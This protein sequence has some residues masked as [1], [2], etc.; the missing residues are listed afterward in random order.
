MLLITRLNGVGDVDDSVVTMVFGPG[1][2]FVDNQIGEERLLSYDFFGEINSVELVPVCDEADE[3]TKGI[4]YN[5][6]SIFDFHR[7]NSIKS[8][9]SSRPDLYSDRTRESWAGT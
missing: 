8:Q 5:A 7:I 3:G 4:G 9:T 1:R 6:I 2:C